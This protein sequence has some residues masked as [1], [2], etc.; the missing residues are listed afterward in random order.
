MS[1][2]TSF[3][4]GTQPAQAVP[5]GL[6]TNFF[7]SEGPGQEQLQ[8]ALASA[9]SQQAPPGSSVSSAQQPN[10]MVSWISQYAA[11]QALQQQQQQNQE[12]TTTTDHAQLPN[13]NRPTYVNAKQYRR[14]LKRR[15]ARRVMEEYYQRRRAAIAAI[16]E[17][18]PYVHES[19]HRHAMKRP[20]GPGGRF[21]KKHELEDYYKQNPTEMEGD[22]GDG[23]DEDCDD[24]SGSESGDHKSK[25]QVGIST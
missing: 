23:C 13:S 9:A 4:M 11:L 8:L 25:R 7:V 17:K 24:L 12:S 14:I 6:G 18:K 2:E 15:D 1:T 20:R 5:G 19:R 16:A 3:L 10:G 22:L 21:L